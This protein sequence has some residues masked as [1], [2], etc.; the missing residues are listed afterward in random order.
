MIIINNNNNIIIYHI[1]AG[2]YNYMPETNH[3]STVYNA[4]S[5]LWLQ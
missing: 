3:V 1:H 2:I 5:I 4:A